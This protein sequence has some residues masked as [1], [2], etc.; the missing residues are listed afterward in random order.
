[1]LDDMDSTHSGM[2]IE[3]REVSSD[4]EVGQSIRLELIVFFDGPSDPRLAASDITV[5]FNAGETP[6]R[7]VTDSHGKAGFF[8]TATQPG[9]VAVTAILDI[10]NKGDAAPSHTFHFVVLTAGVWDDAYSELLNGGE[11][12]GWGGPP[13]FPPIGQTFFLKLSVANVDSALIGR[14]I[15]LG[16]KGDISVSELGLTV[17]PA[18]GVSRKMLLSGLTWQCRG[19]AGGAFGFQ[20]AASRLLNLSPIHRMSLGSASPDSNLKSDIEVQVPG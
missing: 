2:V 4:L 18:L 19:T 7:V 1:M 5:I 16:Q 17:E 13:L 14:D 10:E 12:R 3:G 15:C 9:P 6:T 11:P 20:L 8:Y